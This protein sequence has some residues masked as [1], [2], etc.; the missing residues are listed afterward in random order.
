MFTKEEMRLIIEAVNHG[1]SYRL[2]NRTRMTELTE[3]KAIKKKLEE[4]LKKQKQRA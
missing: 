1:I 3:L 2:N 4:E